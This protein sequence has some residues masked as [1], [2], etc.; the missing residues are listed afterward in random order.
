M[1]ATSGS[2]IPSPSRSTRRRRQRCAVTGS[3]V[4]FLHAGI[5]V[6][7]ADQAGNDDYLAAPT[8]TQTVIVHKAHQSITFTSDPPYSRLRRRDVRRNGHRR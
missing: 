8:V 5:C 7:A 2:A 4:T 1:T 6:I 3:T